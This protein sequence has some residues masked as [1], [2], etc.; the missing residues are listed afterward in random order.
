MRKIYAVLFCVAIVASCLLLASC[1]SSDMSDSEFVGTWVAQTI[2]AF[3]ESETTTD[4]NEV[5]EGGMTIVVN[6]DG[7]VLV[8][9]GDG[10]PLSATWKETSDGFKTKGDAKLKFKTEEGGIS[11]SIV[12]ANIHLVKQ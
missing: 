1:G 11:T 5:L 2:D 6:A 3:G 10:E 4:I 7:T 12:G 8:D 9:L